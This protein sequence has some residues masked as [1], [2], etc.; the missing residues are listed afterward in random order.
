[1]TPNKPLLRPADPRFSSGPCAKHTGWTL[2][3]LEHAH[4]GRSHRIS[5]GVARL[6]QAIE[7]TRAVLEIPADFK[8]AIVPGSDTGA[9]ELALWS[10]LGA[11]GIDVLAWESF[12]ESWAADIT[13]HLKLQDVRVS[14]CLFGEIVDLASV[15]C[16]RDVVFTWNGTSSGVR[17]PNGDWISADRKGL[18]ICDATSAAFAQ[19]LDWQK[20][21]VTTF[22]WQKALGG[23]AAHG[24]IVISPRAIERLKS[25]VPPWPVPKLFR[26]VTGGVIMD[27]VFE[28]WTINTPSMLCVEDYLI[29]LQ[30]AQKIGGLTALIARADANT[31]ILSAFVKRTDWLDFLVHDERARS[32]TSMCL[33][34]VDPAIAGLPRDAQA[35][36]IKAMVAC[37]DAEKAAYDISAH[38]TAP[39]GLR[40]WCGPTVEAS[41]LEAMLPWLDYAFQTV[42]SAEI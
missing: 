32:N 16:D 23:E 4:L 40:I 41:D 35:R 21:D 1:M 28:G 38:R 39:P 2:Q 27:E 19:K 42:K 30:W 24:M 9:M 26:L 6:K 22:S 29:A 36:F 33:N 20:L 11:R 5:S 7:L 8:I 18:T 3:S 15:D 14:R 13:G 25:Y 12:G 34:V 17:V 31:K 37:L 10:L